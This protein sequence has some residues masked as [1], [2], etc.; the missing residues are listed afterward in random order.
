MLLFPV[1]FQASIG[2]Y[3]VVRKIGQ[4]AYDVELLPKSKIHNAFHVSFVKKKIEK[5]VVISKEFPPIDDKKNLVLVLGHFCR[6]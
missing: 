3:K 1:N 2:P 5:Q 4:V 6:S